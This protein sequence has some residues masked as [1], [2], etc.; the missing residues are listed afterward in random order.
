LDLELLE[1]FPPPELSFLGVYTLAVKSWFW[2]AIYLSPACSIGALGS[3][4]Q[5]A[6]SIVEGLLTFYLIMYF[7]R[8]KSVAL[9]G[10][11]LGAAMMGEKVFFTFISCRRVA[12]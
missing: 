1:R 10:V 8:D 2:G 11:G 7:G 9:F 4:A 5:S 3:S 6:A 12:A